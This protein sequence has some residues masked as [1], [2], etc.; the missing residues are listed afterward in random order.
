M[1]HHDVCPVRDG[2]IREHDIVVAPAFVN[3]PAALF[4]RCKQIPLFCSI[5]GSGPETIRTLPVRVLSHQN[6][7]DPA[8]GHSRKKISILELQNFI[9]IV[10]QRIRWIC[11]ESDHGVRCVFDISRIDDFQM[12]VEI[13]RQILQMQDAGFPIFALFALDID[14]M[15]GC[16]VSEMVQGIPNITLATA[17]ETIVSLQS[18]S[19]DPPHIDLVDRS[20]VEDLVKKL[21][22]PFIL[23]CLNRPVSGYDIIREINEQFHVIVPM[24]RIYSY[25]YDLER[26][27]YLKTRT[28]G[29]SKVYE[30]TPAGEEY[31]RRRR[32]DI[33]A[34]LG[35]LFENR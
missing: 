13:K 19:F 5:Y 33:F 15:T 2:Q 17:N 26:R 3:K 1:T 14:S 34:V 29:R 24:A 31:I 12:I 11:K 16:E 32:Q 6:T 28:E 8:I 18:D 25:L 23:S 9:D 10:P 21:L 30:A 35:Y 27:N 7:F 20:I 22:E 4:K